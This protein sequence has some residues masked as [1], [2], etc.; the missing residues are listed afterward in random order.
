MVYVLYDSVD[1]KP[2]LKKNENRTAASLQNIKNLPVTGN[3][4]ITGRFLNIA[5]H[6]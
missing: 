6:P 4:P 5:F 3:K 2:P 1:L